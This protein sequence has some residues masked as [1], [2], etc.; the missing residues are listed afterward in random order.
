MI[1]CQHALAAL[2]GLGVPNA[3]PSDSLNCHDRSQGGFA[4]IEQSRFSWKAKEFPGLSKTTAAPNITNRKLDSPS[5][6]SVRPAGHLPLPMKLR[7]K[8]EP[9][10][11]EQRLQQLRWERKIEAKQAERLGE[12][13]AKKVDSTKSVAAAGRAA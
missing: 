7:G 6:L 3:S 10:R 13:L 9:Q 8:C 12:V 1:P 4:V 11:Y 5:R 2:G